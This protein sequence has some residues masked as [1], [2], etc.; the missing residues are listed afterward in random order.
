MENQSFIAILYAL[1][2]LGIV[3]YISSRNDLSISPFITWCMFAITYF[4]SE[5]AGIVNGVIDAY[6]TPEPFSTIFAAFNEEVFKFVMLLMFLKYFK[7]RVTLKQALFLGGTCCLAFAVSE[8][9]YY[10]T[11]DDLQVLPGLQALVRVVMP[12][13]MHF[14]TGSII[15]IYSYQVFNL[16]R[17]VSNIFIGVG[18]GTAIHTIYNFGAGIV[19][20]YFI[21]AMAVAI[22]TIITVMTYKKFNAEFEVRDEY[23]YGAKRVRAKTSFKDPEKLFSPKIVSK[24]RSKKIN[25]VTKKKNEAKHNIIIY[26]INF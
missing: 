18:I 3:G 23:I 4:L 24:K 14:I 6:G 21:M 11:R 13:P 10:I 17:D 19:D 12:T 7:D 25:I 16:D 22:G 2:L 20:G 5:M 26:F 9:W 8:N 15:A 1:P